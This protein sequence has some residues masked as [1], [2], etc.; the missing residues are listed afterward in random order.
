MTQQ[1]TEV[2]GCPLRGVSLYL[3]CCFHSELNPSGT[4]LAA[5]VAQPILAQKHIELGVSSSA[6]RDGTAVTSQDATAAGASQSP[7][8]R[9]KQRGTSLLATEAAEDGQTRGTGD[10]RAEAVA[11]N[12]PPESQPLVIEEERGEPLEQAANIA[13]PLSSQDE[14]GRDEPQLVMGTTEPT[15]LAAKKVLSDPFDE[16]G[17]E[18]PAEEISGTALETRADD[19]RK[20]TV[21]QDAGEEQSVTVAIA[22][23]SEASSSERL[24]RGTSKPRETE[25]RETEPRETEPC[26]TEPRVSEPPETEGGAGGRQPSHLASGSQERSSPATRRKESAPRSVVPAPPRR[27]LNLEVSRRSRLV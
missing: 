1:S 22:T 25:P 6:S 8:H 9:P 16:S 12:T 19:A 11:S 26:E 15:A 14:T 10:T 4:E 20:D 7:E 3:Y 27:P 18:H 17:K 5:G 23:T 21:E 13:P 2:S 24:L